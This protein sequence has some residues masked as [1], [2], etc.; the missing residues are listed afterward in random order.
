[1]QYLRIMNDGVSPVEGITKFG[2]TTSRGDESKIGQFGSGTKHGIIACLREGLNPTIYCDLTR[3]MFWTEPGEIRDCDGNLKTVQNIH[4]QVSNRKSKEADYTSDFGALDWSVTMGLREFVS[5]ALDAVHNDVK[6]VKIDIVD[7]VG[8]RKGKTIIA[9]PLTPEVQRFYNSLGKHFLHFNRKALMI[10]VISEN[11]PEEQGAIY[12][13]GVFVRNTEPSLFSYNFGSEFKIDESRNASDSDARDCASRVIAR[14]DRLMGV[15]QALPSYR[16]FWERR[17]CEYEMKWQGDRDHW[18]RCW[19]EAHGDNAVMI[20][21]TEGV[22]VDSLLSKGYKPVIIR[23]ANWSRAMQQKGIPRIWDV[24][25]NINDRGHQLENPTAE[26]QATLDTVWAWFELLGFTKGKE[27]PSLQI[28]QDINTDEM[29]VEGYTIDKVVY[30][31]KNKRREHQVYFE[32][33]AHYISQN[34]DFSSGFQNFV[35]NVATQACL[36]GLGS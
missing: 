11:A 35:I 33:I 36:Q 14:S 34:R 9:I 20:E 31:G 6:R 12:R 30:V 19:K 2:V 18:Q 4:Y 8:G 22:F 1:M 27:K 15:F 24:L 25:D 3:V 10:G 5:N 13:K 28:F 32:E 26:D 16:D 17:F 7:K 23:D 29:T 21:G